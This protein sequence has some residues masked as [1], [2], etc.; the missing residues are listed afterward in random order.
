MQLIHYHFAFLPW[1][2][3]TQPKLIC[4]ASQIKNSC[5]IDPSSLQTDTV[6]FKHV[7]SI[8]YKST[9]EIMPA[10]SCSKRAER[11]WER[12][13]HLYPTFKAFLLLCFLLVWTKTLFF[14]AQ[15]TGYPLAHPD[16]TKASRQECEE[17]D[18]HPLLDAVTAA[19]RFI[20][21][22]PWSNRLPGS[23]SITRSVS[24]VWGVTCSLG[25][26]M[27]TRLLNTHNS[28]GKFKAAL[29]KHNKSSKYK[30]SELC[31]NM[32]NSLLV[33]SYFCSAVAT[34]MVRVSCLQRQS[35][36]W[37]R[38][39]TWWLWCLCLR[40]QVLG[41]AWQYLLI[42]AKRTVQWSLSQGASPELKLD[43][44]SSPVL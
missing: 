37:P 22:F 40:M 17:R 32:N 1:S 30:W 13:S 21:L 6:V 41:G 24:P 2:S 20:K 15:S 11:E 9:E 29:K 16:T 38:V 39:P 7:D 3:K 25:M 4:L 31:S 23:K 34:A 14:R 35:L 43:S 44:L 10:D 8:L 42:S 33:S 18:K 12:P 28:T 26:E 27:C 36:H 5:N 19:M